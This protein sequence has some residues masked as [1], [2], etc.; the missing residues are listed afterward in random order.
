VFIASSSSHSGE[1]HC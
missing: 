1:I